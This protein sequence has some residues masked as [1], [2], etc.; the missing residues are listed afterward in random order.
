MKKIIF[1]LSLCLCQNLYAE[2][3]IFS[4][5]GTLLKEYIGKTSQ[6]PIEI[7]ENIGV[8]IK[9]SEVVLSADTSMMRIPT[10]YSSGN[11][12]TGFNFPI[13]SKQ[14]HKISFN[15][16]ACNY[17]KTFNRVKNSTPLVDLVEGSLD[18]ITNKLVITMRPTNEKIDALE[19]RKTGFY[20]I[21]TG[22]YQCARAQPSF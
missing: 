5:K 18:G 7:K 8:I 14:N 16:F 2:D 19:K 20:S 1:L 12:K 21:E 11:I 10:Q 17:E 22:E 6:Q 9:N 13:C 15:N 4:C 3:L